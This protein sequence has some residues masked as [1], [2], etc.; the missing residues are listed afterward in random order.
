MLTLK[1]LHFCTFAVSF[2]ATAT[3]IHNRSGNTHFAFVWDGCQM[4]TNLS[5]G[6]CDWGLEKIK[7]TASDWLPDCIF[8]GNLI[9]NC[10]W[11]FPINAYWGEPRQRVL[12]T[13]VLAL[14]VLD[15]KM[16]KRCLFFF[17]A[18][19]AVLVKPWSHN[20]T[21]QFANSGHNLVKK[22]IL[23]NCSTC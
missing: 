8:L 19:V 14:K 7:I 15:A 16:Q 22:C 1:G 3:T 12:R 4:V 21:D 6:L 5:L 13:S 20:P 2:T 10:N 17:F 11:S 18:P 9:K 23:L